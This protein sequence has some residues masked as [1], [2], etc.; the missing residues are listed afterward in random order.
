MFSAFNPSKCTHT[1]G[2]VGSRRCSARGAVGGLVPCSR[3]SPQSWT[4]PAEI[5]TQVQ[6]SGYKSDAL[7]IRATTAHNLTISKNSFTL[8]LFKRLNV[9]R[10]VFNSYLSRIYLLLMYFISKCTEIRAFIC[11]SIMTIS[12][13]HCT[14]YY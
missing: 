1:P 12:F 2:A 8:L 3:V 5:R 13:I 11:P 9:R 4:I 14:I 6:D 10:Y 7:S